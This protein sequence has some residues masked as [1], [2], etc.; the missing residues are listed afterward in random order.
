[1]KKHIGSLALVSIM[2]VESTI[3]ASLV[4][5]VDNIQPHKGPI[6]I[7][8]FTEADVFPIVTDDLNMVILQSKDIVTTQI[9]EGLEEGKRYAVAVFQDNN[10]SNELEKN[11]FGAPKE[12]Y[13][14][15]QKMPRFRAPKFDEAAITL[16]DA[17]TNTHITLR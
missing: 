8:V 9:F 14:F 2:M 15:S 13:G 1:M 12:P 17:V 10:F 11:F 4:V 3:A 6:H 16:T 5:T 7:G